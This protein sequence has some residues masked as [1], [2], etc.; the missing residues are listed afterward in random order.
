M[1]ANFGQN[2]SGVNPRNYF[3]PDFGLDN[4]ILYTRS[5]IKNSEK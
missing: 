5:N 4:E 3:V 1:S 2:E